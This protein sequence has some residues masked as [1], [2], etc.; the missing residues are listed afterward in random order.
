LQKNF[1]APIKDQDM[2]RAMPQSEPMDFAAALLADHFIALIDDIEYF[3]IHK[4]LV[5]GVRK[6]I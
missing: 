2:N 1:P 3:F 4:L 5:A 6:R